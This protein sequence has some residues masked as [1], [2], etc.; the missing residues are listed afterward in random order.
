MISDAQNF[1]LLMLVLGGVLLLSVPIEAMLRRFSLPAMVGF[2]TLGLILSTATGRV[3]LITPQVIEQFDLLAQLGILALLFRVGLESDLNSLLGQLQRATIIWLPNMLVPAVLAF[4]L[5]W[6]WPG[7]GL[8]PALVV[9]IAASATSIGV[10]VAAW[11]EAGA[12]NTEDGALLLDVAALDDLS[13]LILLGIA[14]AVIPSLHTASDTSMVPEAL[15][16]AGGQLAKIAAFCVVCFAFSQFVEQRLSRQFAR[17]SP[18]IGPFVFAAGAAFVIAAFAESLGFSMAIGALFAG[19]AFSRDPSE[20]R[21]DVA[22]GYLLALFEP[23][24]FVS[25]GL[26]VSLTDI[27]A[28]TVLASALLFVLV[29]GKLIGAGLPAALLFGR[30][31]GLLIGVGMIP[32]AEIYLLVMMHGLML[33][34]WAVPPSLYTAAVLAG[35]GTCVIGPLLTGRLLARQALIGQSA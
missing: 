23:F 25:I 26:S 2:I 29:A 21:I 20:R 32:R 17:L 16:A 28:A 3:P 13:T 14:F 10:S 33:G 31:T 15:L 9:G 7:L 11:K 4:G 24:F 27:G 35:I 22:F 34:P 12:I 30:S 5:L 19:L 18:H 8:I 1:G 6:A